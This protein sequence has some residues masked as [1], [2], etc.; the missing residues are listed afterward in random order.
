MVSPQVRVGRLACA[1]VHVAAGVASTAGGALEALEAQ[2]LAVPSASSAEAH[3]K[4]ITS[5]SHVAGTDGDFAMA[6]YVRAQM[7]SYGLDS[8]I[9]NVTVSLNYP[10]ESPSLTLIPTAAGAKVEVVDLEERMLAEDKTS[11]TVWRNHTFHGYAP[12]GDATGSL[13]YANYGRPKDFA[14]LLALGVNVSGKIVLVRYGENFRGLKVRNAQEAGAVAVLIYSDPED[15][16]YAQGSTYPEGAWRPSFG[17][18]R[19][20]VQFNSLCSGDPTRA[21]GPKSVEEMCGYKADELIPKIPSIPLSY[22][23]AQGLLEQLGGHAAPSSFKGGLRLNY[24]VGPSASFRLRL[25][26]K[27]RN[28]VTPIP[29]VITTILGQESVGEAGL[30]APEVRP[31]VLGNHRDAWVYGA[32]DPN[33]GTASLLEVAKGLGHLKKHGGWRPKRT[34][35]LCSWSGEEYGLLGSTAWAELNEELVTKAVA[36]LNV[37]A[38]VSGNMLSAGGS[39][40]LRDAFLEAAASVEAPDGGMLKPTKSWEPIGSGSDYAVFLDHF[41]VASMDFEFKRVGALG[42]NAPY[43]QY[44]SVYDSFDW[45]SRF[46]AGGEGAGKPKQAFEYMRAAARVWGLLA[47]RFADADVLPFNHTAQSEAIETWRAELAEAERGL[48]TLSLQKAILQYSKAAHGS[49]EEKS[50]L[51][52]E[53]P[54]QLRQQ[55]AADL[56]DRLAFTERQFALETGLPDRKWFRNL[57]QAPGIDEGYAPQTLPGVRDGLR[58][59]VAEGQTQLEVLASRVSAAAIFLTGPGFSARQIVV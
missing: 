35:V 43:G 6:E 10:E 30:D 15:D 12:S 20:S 58:R 17:V 37:D 21:A 13:V 23:A 16:G 36:Y 52:S 5:R 57:L 56:N 2:Y 34:I 26:T 55:A 42:K 19:G 51:Q 14:T 49:Q 38:A 4:Y 9:E 31:V 46:G 33:S 25:K 22:G 48:D 18:Q 44:H 41:G 39:Y 1:L 47:I 24:T 59:G 53:P 28:V 11:D 32:V 8:K 7:E 29:N 50:R 54:S 27:N 45:I 40:A 3:L